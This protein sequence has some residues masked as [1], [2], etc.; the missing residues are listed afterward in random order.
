[1]VVDGTCG[2]YQ[3]DTYNDIF[4]RATHVGSDMRSLLGIECGSRVGIMAP[5]SAVWCITELVMIW[6]FGLV[7]MCLVIC[8]CVCLMFFA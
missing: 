4:W 6:F 8:E 7:L 3:F 1:V 2:A 5:N